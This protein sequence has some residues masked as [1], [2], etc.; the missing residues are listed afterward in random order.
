MPK[1]SF[2]A[3]EEFEQT[4]KNAT[5]LLID[6]FENDKERAKDYERQNADYS[7]KKKRH[8]DIGMCISDRH[9]YIYYV[10]N[11]YAGS[12]TDYGIFKKEFTPEK[13]W[14]KNQRIIVDLG[15]TGID[16]DYEIKELFIGHKKPRKSKENPN[17][18][19]TDLEKQWN[20]FVSKKRIYV[21]H[22]IG[23]MKIF[24][25]LKNKC[26]LKSKELKN[27]ILGVAAG[28]WNYKL[29]FKRSNA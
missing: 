26:R 7:G 8:T 23:G 21:E 4:V 1:R 25:I 16:K 24:R 18:K 3:E 6:G 2:E 22:A 5:E 17:P 20:K 13:N 9:R 29:L 15:F 14:F 10:S 27:R 28:L 12:E 19:L 11:Y